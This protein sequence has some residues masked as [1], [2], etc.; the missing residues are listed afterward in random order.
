MKQKFTLTDISTIDE[1]LET[2]LNLGRKLGAGPRSEDFGPPNSAKTEETSF[3][4]TIRTVY[5]IWRNPWMSIGHDTYI[6]DVMKN[7]G[8]DKHFWKRNTIPGN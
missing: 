5:F 6:H 7:W 3:E 2:I 4:K 1:A 8:L